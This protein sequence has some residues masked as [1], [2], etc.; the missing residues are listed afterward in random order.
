MKLRQMWSVG[1]ALDS[2]FWSAGT[3]SLLQGTR[4]R[5]DT[6]AVALSPEA[7]LCASRTRAVFDE[8][9]TDATGKD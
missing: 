5:K 6:A 3:F 4:V 1:T 7:L 2:V 9:R 8:N